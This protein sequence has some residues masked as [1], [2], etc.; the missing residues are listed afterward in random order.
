MKAILKFVY[1]TENQDEVREI[2]VMKNAQAYKSVLWH[3]EQT[4]R[5]ELKYNTQLSDE[6]HKAYE[7]I[8]TLLNDLCNKEGVDIYS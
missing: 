4:L 5:N 6:G 8:R 7:T 1:D 3:L 2:E